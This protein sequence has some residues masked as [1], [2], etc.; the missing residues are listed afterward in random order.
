[1]SQSNK[2]IDEINDANI[3]SSKVVS[4]GIDGLG[5]IISQ[6]TNP[7][8]KQRGPQGHTG[9]LKIKEVDEPAAKVAK[10][11]ESFMDKVQAKINEIVSSN[12]GKTT[13]DGSK[14]EKGSKTKDEKDDKDDKEKT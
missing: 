3:K 13:T 10:G 14:K 5:E 2:T 7:D 4:K 1:M 12:K 9:K 11:T 8:G 6:S